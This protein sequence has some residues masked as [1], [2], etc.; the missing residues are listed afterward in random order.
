MVA[1]AAVTVL[2]L[3]VLSG[4]LFDL[5][6]LMSVLPAQTT[7]KPNAALCFVLLG[8]GLC[9]LARDGPI[10]RGTARV[11]AGLV[12]LIA[13]ATL[14]EYGA[15]GSLGIDELLF[16]DPRTPPELNPGRMAVATAVGFLLTAAALLLTARGVRHRGPPARSP[17]RSVGRWW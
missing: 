3:L 16:R 2:G 6:N 9:L 7:M 10:A 14:I 15:S 13:G 5:P 11:A 17:W 4:W 1:G 8:A 12:T